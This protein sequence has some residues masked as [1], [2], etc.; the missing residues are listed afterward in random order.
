MLQYGE[1]DGSFLHRLAA[2]HGC[3]LR[4][5]GRKVDVLGQFTNEI[6]PLQWRAEGG[7]YAFRTKGRIYEA[8]I[9][10]VNYDRA[11]ATSREIRDV[12]EAAPAE[13]SLGALRAGAD[14]GSA[15]KKIADAL[16]D[17]FLSGGHDRFTEELRLEARRR[18]IHSCTAYGESREAAILI[19][20]KVDIEGE[21][22][23]SGRYGVYRL[24]HLW[25]LGKG[26]C[27]RFWCMPFQ[28]YLDE[29]RPSPSM[30]RNRPLA[31][32]PV[33]PKDPPPAVV[34]E[35]AAAPFSGRQFGVCVAR[36]LD[37]V[38]PADAARVRVQFPWE[39]ESNEGWWAPVVT[40]HAGSGRGFYFLP[41]IGDE[42]LVAFEQGDPNRP[43]VIG[44]LWNGSDRPPND[45]LHGDEQ[46]NNDIKRIVTK[47][48]NRIVMDDMEGSETI[49][50]ATPQH[51]RISM[52]DGEKTLLIHSDGDINIHAGGT[53]H[54]RCKQFLR[55]VG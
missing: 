26:Y 23:T 27:N 37:N 19:G 34:A 13:D 9:S 16:Y 29:S 10:G 6:C 12:S 46:G 55:E 41:E 14:G 4:A 51:I 24:E 17:K 21:I 31:A 8:A 7:L 38:D 52:F 28:I 39:S 45:G 35:T 44:S 50:V 2:R 5:Q 22:E 54:I 15:E 42:V 33:L 47:S 36:V 20:G 18:Q 48:G 1:T 49:V 25:E 30:I 3:F 53:V 40:P 32:Q 11:E 43:V